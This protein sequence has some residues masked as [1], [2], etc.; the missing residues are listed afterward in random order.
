MRS[1][2]LSVAQQYALL[3]LLKLGAFGWNSAVGGYDSRL[4]HRL[5][6]NVTARLYGKGLVDISK[7]TRARQTLTVYW[8]TETGKAIA[9]QL[10]AEEAAT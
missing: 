5:N 9:A 8:L 3:Q 10:S 4:P 7:R 1:A 2:D 6:P